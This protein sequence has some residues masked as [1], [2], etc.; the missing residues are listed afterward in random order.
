MEV[1]VNLRSLI[2]FGFAVAFFQSTPLRADEMTVLKQ[3]SDVVSAQCLKHYGIN[4]KAPVKGLQDAKISEVDKLACAFP[5]A[6]QKVEIRLSELEKLDPQSDWGQKAYITLA[7]RVYNFDYLINSPHD[8]IKTEILALHPDLLVLH[9]ILRQITPYALAFAY[10]KLSSSNKNFVMTARSAAASTSELTPWSALLR[11]AKGMDCYGPEREQCLQNKTFALQQLLQAVKLLEKN[12]NL[13][14][15]VA[16]YS[17]TREATEL[18]SAPLIKIALNLQKSLSGSPI[19]FILGLRTSIGWGSVRPDLRD[20][21]N[22]LAAADED[23]QTPT[24]RIIN[25]ETL[26]CHTVFAS[27]I[28]LAAEEDANSVRKAVAPFNLF[29]SLLKSNSSILNDP[30]K[31]QPLI[32]QQSCEQLPALSSELNLHGVLSRFQAYQTHIILLSSH[33]EGLSS[34]A[35]KNRSRRFALISDV[36]QVIREVKAREMAVATPSNP[37]STAQQLFDYVSNLVKE[38]IK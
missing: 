2:L 25:L 17:E 12:D 11:Q 16:H 8:E 26:D 5:Y 10:P 14:N 19:D 9:R 18:Q 33:D 29:E 27:F 3:L 20:T 4:T 23:N 38:D 31:L 7:S 34:E 15:Y 24:N 6:V 28:A 35:I 22:Y 30:L 13:Y 36:E 32:E 21:L 37:S 1:K